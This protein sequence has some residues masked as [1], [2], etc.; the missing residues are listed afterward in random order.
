MGITPLIT[1]A[2]RKFSNGKAIL[3]IEDDHLEL[4]FI[5]NDNT[6]YGFNAEAPVDLAGGDEYFRRLMAFS[7]AETF[8]P[9]QMQGW[10]AGNRYFDIYPTSGE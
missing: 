2:T 8:D 7:A 9:K 1:Y 6:V 5:G 4:I 10:R 3:L